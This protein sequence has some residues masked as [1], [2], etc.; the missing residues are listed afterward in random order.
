MTESTATLDFKMLD[1]LAFAAAR[2]RLVKESIP[3]LAAVEIGPFFELLNLSEDG[4]LPSP[5]DEG[6]LTSSSLKPMVGALQSGGNHWFGP[7]ANGVGFLRTAKPYDAVTWTSF[8]L[9]GQKAAV[10]AGFPK[11]IA[12][13][14]T[15]ALGELLSNI[16]EHCEKPASGIVAFSSTPGRFEIAATDRGVGVLNS[17][18]T[19]SSF[20]TLDD[21][22]NA[23]R[24]AISDGVSRFEFAHDR[25]HGFQPIFVGLANLNGTLRFRSG[26]HALMIEGN[27]LSTMAARTSQKPA[28]QGFQISVN[29]LLS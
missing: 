21:H 7:H 29:C 5:Y 19:N 1:G 22:G 10:S 16:Y 26:D 17:L 9:A 27:N 14:L 11:F 6:W 15:A 18:R 8:G 24:L 12:A 2:G 13:Q 25:G 4:L 20:A 3:S 28:T 23:L